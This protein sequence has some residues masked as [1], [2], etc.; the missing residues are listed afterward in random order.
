[1]QRQ[2]TCICS[3]FLYSVWLCSSFP[4]TFPT[5]WRHYAMT[6][7]LKKKKKK[8][9]NGPT[10]YWHKNCS[11]R[12]EHSDHC[13]LFKCLSDIFSFYLLSSQ[14]HHI[15]DNIHIDKNSTKHLNIDLQREE[16]T[17]HLITV[18]MFA[19]ATC[20]LASVTVCLE[21]LWWADDC[22]GSSLTLS[23]ILS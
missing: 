4:T 3:D 6:N 17:F 11:L 16:S 5:A 9:T 7:L 1:M 8:Y 13:F 2:I 10:Q 12:T 20:W 22:N 21:G 14:S 18:S 23:F 19:L 15:K